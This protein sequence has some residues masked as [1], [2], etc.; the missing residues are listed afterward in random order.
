MI[1]SKISFYNRLNG[2]LASSEVLSEYNE[3]WLSIPSSYAQFNSMRK[4]LQLRMRFLGA[5]VIL[6]EF[7]IAMVNRSLIRI[8]MRGG[9]YLSHF[10]SGDCL[11][12]FWLRCITYPYHI[13]IRAWSDEND[14]HIQI[15]WGM[16]NERDHHD[17]AP[18][19]VCLDMSGFSQGKRQCMIILGAS[20]VLEL[21]DV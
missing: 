18:E 9:G 5:P 11:P 1:Y 8:S 14:L 20:I 19:Q 3:N 12:T 16:K 21:F 2:W 13:A 17:C 7:S 15:W 6:I 10:S 4:I